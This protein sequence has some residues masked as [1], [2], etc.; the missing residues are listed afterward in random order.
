MCN[1][2]LCGVCRTHRDPDEDYCPD[3]RARAGFASAPKR[4][5]TAWLDEARFSSKCVHKGC[6]TV[7]KEGERA[8]WFPERQRLM[9]EDCG[10]EYLRVAV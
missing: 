4:E 1:K 10:E 5:L 8:L 3:H 9:C 6:E 7:V 2:R